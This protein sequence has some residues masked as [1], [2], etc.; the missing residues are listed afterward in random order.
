MLS[1]FDGVH[2]LLSEIAFPV[3]MQ[4]GPSYGKCNVTTLDTVVSLKGQENATVSWHTP[5]R[6]YTK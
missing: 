3:A 4:P 1:V 5:N 2:T 6:V